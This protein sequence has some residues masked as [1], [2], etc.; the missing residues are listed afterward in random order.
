MLFKINYAPQT[1]IAIPLAR[2]FKGIPDE[3]QKSLLVTVRVQKLKRNERLFERGDK[4][5]TMYLVQTGR[6]EISLITGEGK[7]LVLNQV[8]P[9][10]CFGEIAMIDKTPRTASA[11]A[12]ENSILIPITSSIFSETVRKC[13][14]L[15]INLL[16][17]MCERIR[18]ISDSVEEYAAHPL[19]LRLARR[20]FTLHKNFCAED[21]WIKITQNDLADFAGATREATNKI[22]IGWKAIGLIRLGRGKISI[23][24]P[25]KLNQIA[26]RNFDN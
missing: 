16:E 5:G 13:P 10:H 26:Y 22:L 8:G 18:W 21:G 6:I 11:I 25:E 24:V 12:L 19:D 14:Q 1:G 3:M 2:L 7:K 17:I 4:G 9:G 20:L 15:A 23:A